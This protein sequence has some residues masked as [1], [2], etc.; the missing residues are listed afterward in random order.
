MMRLIDS[1]TLD[2]LR[3]TSAANPKFAQATGAP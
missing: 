3:D 2:L 1:A